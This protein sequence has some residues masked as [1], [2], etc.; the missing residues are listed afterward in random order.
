MRGG[1]A[2]EAV[3]VQARRGGASKAGFESVAGSRPGGLS[4]PCSSVATLG[5][6]PARI[7]TV[8]LAAGW[9]LI[10][11]R[12]PP[13]HRWGYSAAAVYRV[14]NGGRPT[15]RF[16]K[17]LVELERMYAAE[18]RAL[19]DGSILM[20]PVSKGRGRMMYVRHDYRE[21]AERGV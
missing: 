13:R 1:W 8:L 5:N 18:I 21:G 19:A 20:Q 11:G 16:V 6:Y 17:R 9:V 15:V 12:D 7:R 2:A 10:D 3:R 4:P 14:L